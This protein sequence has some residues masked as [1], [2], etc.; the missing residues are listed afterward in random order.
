[1][2]MYTIGC[3]EKIQNQERAQ[4]LSSRARIAISEKGYYYAIGD[5]IDLEYPY[6]M[7]KC[8]LWLVAAEEHI[9]LM[10]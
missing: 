4:L 6:V 10:I 3:I 8:I 7:I 1:M 5:I 9:Q 2:W